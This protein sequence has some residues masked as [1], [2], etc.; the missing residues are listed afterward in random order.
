MGPPVCSLQP[1][2]LLCPL[3]S[4]WACAFLARQGVPCQMQ[5]EPGPLKLLSTCFCFQSYTGH[6]IL[7]C[8]FSERGAL[9]QIGG[10]QATLGRVSMLW[11]LI[12]PKHTC[13]TGPWSKQPGSP[14]P[15]RHTRPGSR[16]SENRRDM[17]LPPRA[18]LTLTAT[19]A[20]RGCQ[21]GGRG[22]IHSPPSAP[23]PP[24]QLLQGDPFQHQ[25]QGLQPLPPTPAQHLAATVMRLDSL[26]TAPGLGR[27]LS[28]G[29]SGHGKGRL[30]GITH[31]W[32]DR[33][34]SCQAVRGQLL[35]AQPR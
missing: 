34:C 24:H 17:E 19:A 5:A 32:S 8:H 16:A 20:P 23:S 18:A 28:E 11:H 27:A 10:A 9:V 25:H 22:R 35:A 29:G 31:H 30:P 3:T 26:G 4:G 21:G 1:S 33:D 14:L 12:H 7:G 6:P 15:G 13:R 2:P